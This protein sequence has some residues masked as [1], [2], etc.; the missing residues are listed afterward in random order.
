[1]NSSVFCISSKPQE[2]RGKACLQHLQ[3][4]TLLQDFIYFLSLLHFLILSLLEFRGYFKRGHLPALA[5]PFSELPLSLSP[6]LWDIMEVPTDFLLYPYFRRNRSTPPQSFQKPAP[7][8]PQHRLATVSYWVGGWFMVRW[9]NGFMSDDFQKYIYI[10]VVGGEAAEA[11]T[12][13]ILG[14]PRPLPHSCHVSTIGI[15]IPFVS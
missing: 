8:I 14:P 2:V 10:F 9:C 12:I 5:Q 6:F 15:M 4:K 13:D 1:M 11:A 7:A 3:L